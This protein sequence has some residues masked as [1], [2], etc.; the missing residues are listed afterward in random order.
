MIACTAYEVTHRKPSEQTLHFFSQK[1]P[2]AASS[3]SVPQLARF[4]SAVSEVL[5][6]PPRRHY[7]S[8]FILRLGALTVFFADFATTFATVT[9]S[10]A[11]TDSSMST[12][13]TVSQPFSS[14]T[15]SAT[16]RTKFGSLQETEIWTWTPVLQGE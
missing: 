9:T 15:S 14:R 1:A 7:R 11:Q 2:C 6:P 3:Q 5:N 13:A 10:P 4:L 8:L 12:E 16:S